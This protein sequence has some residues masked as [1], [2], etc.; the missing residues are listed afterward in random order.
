MFLFN[1]F[2]FNSTAGR[3]IWK[4]NRSVIISILYV[5]VLIYGVCVFSADDWPGS[6]N[7]KEIFKLCRK[8]TELLHQQSVSVYVTLSCTDEYTC[9]I[10][11]LH[12][13]GLSNY[14]IIPVID[15]PG[16]ILLLYYSI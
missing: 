16:V 11:F 8:F 7:S 1:S 9:T 5:I 15:F 13:N 4:K 6:D 12:Y 10:L 14:T 2:F 3:S